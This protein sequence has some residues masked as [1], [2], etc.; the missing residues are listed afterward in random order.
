MNASVKLVK[1]LP[2]GEDCAALVSALLILAAYVEV[3]SRL[4]VGV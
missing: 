1:S 4:A 3:L 2:A